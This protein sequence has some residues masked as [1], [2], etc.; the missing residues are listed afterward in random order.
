[1][2]VRGSAW[3]L[4][5]DTERFQDKENNDLEEERDIGRHNKHKYSKKNVSKR[6]VQMRLVIKSGYYSKNDYLALIFAATI[7]ERLLFKSG[8]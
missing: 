2:R 5:I 1:M 3:E 7:R 8:G 4:N 6:F